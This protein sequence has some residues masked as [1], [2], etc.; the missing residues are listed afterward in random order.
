MSSVG[1]SW[2]G[3]HM[4]VQGEDAEGVYGSED[5]DGHLAGRR[6]DLRFDI[7]VLLGSRRNLLRA[8]D[9]LQMGGATITASHFSH[10]SRSKTMQR[11]RLGSERRRHTAARVRLEQEIPMGHFVGWFRI[12]L[13]HWLRGL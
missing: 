7:T 11:V 10:I 6:T 1:Q 3:L 12:R 4:F 13:S 8:S 9:P 2:N 5:G